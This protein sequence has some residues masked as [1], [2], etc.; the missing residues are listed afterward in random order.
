M[1]EMTQAPARADRFFLFF[2]LTLFLIIMIGFPGH[3]L[4]NPERLPPI[5]PLL[6]VHAVSMGAWYALLLTQTALVAAGR[7]GLH[8]KLGAASL[9]LAPLVLGTGLLVSYQNMSRTGDP[10]I[11]IANTG[12]CV[13]F[14]A[15]YGTALALRA[16]PALHKRLMM[17][18]ALALMLPAY[19]RFVQ[20][21]GRSEME[22]IIP[23]LVLLLVLPVYDL[24]SQRRIKK[25][26][27]ACVGANFAFIAFLLAALPPPD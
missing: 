3:A 24:I 9:L 20:L 11:F 19:A 4:L 17:F 22:A 12:N 23:W 7:V 25:I 26:T 8:R 2:A 1:A 5:R 18:A 13:L 16:R 15:F 27:L 21:F 14:V 10:T 6:H